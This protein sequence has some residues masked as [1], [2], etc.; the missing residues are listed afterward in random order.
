MIPVKQQTNQVVADSIPLNFS[1]EIIEI[2]EIAY[3]PETKVSN[4]NE[5]FHTFDSTGGL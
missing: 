4:W 2:I 1:G 5:I 3:L